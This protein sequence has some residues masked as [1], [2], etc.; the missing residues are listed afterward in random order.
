VG[1]DSLCFSDVFSLVAYARRPLKVKE[2]REAIGVLQSAN[3]AVPDPDAVPFL[4]SLQKFAPL[5]EVQ[6]EWIDESP[7]QLYHSTA[8]DFLV[9][10]PETLANASDNTQECESG[11]RITTCKIA[12]AC[13]YYLAQHRYEN[14][15]SR[16]DDNWYDG[17]NK[18]V[19][20]ETHSFLVYSAKYWD[21]HLDNIDEIERDRFRGRIERFIKSPN[22]RTCI[23]VQSLWVNGQFKVLAR[24]ALIP[25][26]R[27]AFPGWF[28]EEET[29]K[30]L[31][32]NYVGF[33]HEWMYILRCGICECS[34]P[35]AV[36]PVAGEVDR[37][38]W[39]ALDPENFLS[40]LAGRYKSFRFHS[41][42][43]AKG[44]EG[45]AFEG[46]NSSGDKLK[47]LRLM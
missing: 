3:P 28:A 23:Q 24:R 12:D 22:F 38:W 18:P 44:A 8:R 2:L 47:I 33:L 29:G 13:L 34:A 40:S 42:D 5:L 17:Y 11:L 10:F 46:I 30:K 7:C 9:R 25:L 19:L 21:K 4:K 36:R 26:F 32:E 1:I 16:R 6:G 45:F 35:C 43:S 37:I 15:L 27:R 31:W 39:G 14:L 20:P 41:K